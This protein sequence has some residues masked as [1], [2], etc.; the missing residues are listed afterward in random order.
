MPIFPIILS[1]FRLKNSDVL[2]SSSHAVAKGCRVQKGQLHICYCHTPMRY[3]WS[4]ED[5]YLRNLNSIGYWFALWI[6][7]RIRRWD[8]RTAQNVHYFIANSE[9]IQKQIAQ[10]YQ[11]DA[12][13]IYPPVQT[14]KF[15]LNPHP[16]QSF[17]LAPG[18][19]VNYKR[20]DLIIEAFRARPDLKLVLLGDGYDSGKIKR[21]LQDI[22]NVTWIGY[23]HDDEVILYMQQAKA[24]IFASKEDFG[25][26]CVEAQSTGTPVI[27]LR[28]GG[29]LETVLEGVTGYFFDEQTPESILQAILKMESK[30]LQNHTEIRQHALQFDQTIFQTK[31]QTYVRKMYHE[32]KG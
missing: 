32:F 4:L 20:F 27:A 24:C 25:I 6:L 16:R 18:R 23:Q 14:S 21:L 30:P 10:F 3:A 9:H 12:V 13:V 17:Y 19:F 29:H 28:Y 5:D 15:A 1:G 31:I 7:H 2:I 22:P 8:R 26:M 11:R